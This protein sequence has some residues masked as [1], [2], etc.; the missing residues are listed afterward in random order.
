MER[1]K[2]YV[3]IDSQ[4]LKKGV[5][6]TVKNSSGKIIYEGW[7][8]DFSQLYIYLKDNFRADKIF[9][10]LGFLPDQTKRYTYLQSIGYIIVFKPTYRGKGGIKGNCDAELVL[11]AMIEYSNY[12]D[13]VIVSG[14]GD[15][16]CLI[17]HLDNNKKL[18]SLIIPCKYK[19]SSLLRKFEQY[20]IYISKLK[21]RLEKTQKSA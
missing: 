9:L 8:L 13:A 21:H 2:T 5:E 7:D 4:N 16:H 20:H 19:Y 6:Q 14:D 10:F 12:T 18:R 3:F 11:H 15:F 1:G 17:E